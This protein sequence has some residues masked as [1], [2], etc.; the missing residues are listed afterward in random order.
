MVGTNLL[1]STEKQIKFITVKQEEIVQK[2][3]IK[4]LDRYIQMIL[5][6]VAHVDQFVYLRKSAN[7]QQ[8][9]YDLEVVDYAL[10][11]KDEKNGLR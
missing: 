9:P 5:R 8:D 6:N 10:L 4:Q 2:R 3:P 11:K 7:Y 1:S